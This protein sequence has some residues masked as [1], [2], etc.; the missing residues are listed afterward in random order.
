MILSDAR[1]ALR[2]IRVIMGADLA[3]HDDPDVTV[4]PVA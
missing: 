2:Q 1:R 4:C 3:A